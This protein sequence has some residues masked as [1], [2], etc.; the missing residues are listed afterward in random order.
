[1]GSIP[2]GKIQYS[3]WL[4]DHS[5]LYRYRYAIVEFVHL[6]KRWEESVT[7]RYGSEPNDLVFSVSTPPD[8]QD[9]SYHVQYYYGI[10]NNYSVRSENRIALTQ[11]LDLK[12]NNTTVVLVEMPVPNTY[13]Y[14]FDN[15]D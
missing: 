9:A 3:G 1:M 4:I 6:H 10:L 12:S 2:A 13:F 7:N 15:P 8:P 5:Y 14:F 11:I